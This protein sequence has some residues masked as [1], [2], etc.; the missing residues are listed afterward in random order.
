MKT[1]HTVYSYDLNQNT[2]IMKK[3]FRTS[4]LFPSFLRYYKSCIK[5]IFFKK[6]WVAKARLFQ[7]NLLA[8]TYDQFP[9]YYNSCFKLRKKNLKQD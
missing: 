4:K 6:D 9:E 7:E 8:K 5:T 2:G 1:L 3:N